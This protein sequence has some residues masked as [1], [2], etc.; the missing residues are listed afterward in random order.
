MI[1]LVKLIC[2][3]DVSWFAYAAAQSLQDYD[4]DDLLECQKILLEK[5]DVNRDGKINKDE[6]TMVLMSCN[7]TAVESG[8]ELEQST[9]ESDE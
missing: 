9:S 1:K 4:A 5:C 7:K 2:F 6:L 3:F 8:D